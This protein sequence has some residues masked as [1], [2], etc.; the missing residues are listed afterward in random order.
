LKNAKYIETHIHEQ[1]R[2]LLILFIYNARK[3]AKDGFRQCRL[4][5]LK[6]GYD[7]AAGFLV[8]ALWY[9]PGPGIAR[10]Q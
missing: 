10:V 4:F 6:L 3:Y 1:I 2:H 8:K 5:K 9:I 7:F